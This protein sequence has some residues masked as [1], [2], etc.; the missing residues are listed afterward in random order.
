MHDSGSSA[1]AACLILSLSMLLNSSDT[2]AAEFYCQTG[3]GRGDKGTHWNFLLRLQSS[4][5]SEPL[6]AAAVGCRVHALVVL[7]ATIMGRLLG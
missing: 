4:N 6:A 5:Q 7:I 1:G 3:S 2:T